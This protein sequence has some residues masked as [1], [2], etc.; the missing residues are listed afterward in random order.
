MIFDFTVV[1]KKIDG[2]SIY[3]KEVFNRLVLKY[4]PATHDY[5]LANKSP[6]NVKGKTKNVFLNRLFVFRF[7][8]CFFYSPT[9]H[10]RLFDRNKVISVLDITPLL[11]PSKS[12]FQ[13]FYFNFYLRYSVIFAKRIV[14][15][16]H[17]SKNLICKYYNVPCDKINVIYCGT[18]IDKEQVKDVLNLPE[19]YFLMLGVHSEYKNFDRAFRALSLLDDD[20]KLVVTGTALSV[21]EAASTDKRIVHFS[22]LNYG[23]VRYLYENAIALL[24]PSLIEGFGMPVLEAARLKVPIITSKNS[25]MSEFLGEGAAIY[26]DPTSIEE[27]LEAI[28]ELLV[29]DCSSMLSIAYEN[30][31]SLTW[32]NHCEELIRIIE[33]ESSKCV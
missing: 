22:Q 25:A 11:I 16:S 33:E 4:P 15:I 5:W 10:G 19:K 12:F 14:T 9:Q 27:I 32:D 2:L 8:K 23:Q 3:A 30:T 24:Y 21:L 26:V 28:K 20:V 31:I 13:F 18:D 6:L 17:F 29:V 7:S 1:S